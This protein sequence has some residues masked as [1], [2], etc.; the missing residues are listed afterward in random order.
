M[1]VLFYVRFVCFCVGVWVLV[2]MGVFLCGRFWCGFVCV[3]IYVL[4][5]A[6]FCVVDVLIYYYMNN[7]CVCVNNINCLKYTTHTIY[8][9][10]TYRSGLSHSLGAP[11]SFLIVFSSAGEGSCYIMYV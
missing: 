9:I 3:Y 1:C 5:V 4:Y 7:S 2:F 8:K 6:C 11:P 10:H